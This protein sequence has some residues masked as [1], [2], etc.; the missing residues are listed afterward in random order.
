MNICKKA[1]I[2]VNQRV[3]ERTPNIEHRT[4]NIEGKRPCPD[5]P[6]GVGCS[7][8]GVLPITAYKKRAGGPSLT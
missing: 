4:Q 8:F 6:F 3:E 1:R 7:M 2:T 5:E